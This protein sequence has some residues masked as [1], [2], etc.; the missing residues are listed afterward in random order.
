MSGSSAEVICELQFM[1]TQGV[2]DSDLSRTNSSSA[3]FDASGTAAPGINNAAEVIA[4]VQA[5]IAPVWPLR[6]FVAVNPFLGLSDRSFLNARRL[7]RSVADCE[8]L[9][10]V[11]YYQ[12][13]YQR[14]DFTGD[15]LKSAMDELSDSTGF[16]HLKLAAVLQTLSETPVSRSAAENPERVIRSMA[17][18]A[19][20][21]T[22]CEWAEIVREEVGRHCAAMYDE[23]QAVWNSPWKALTL[24]Q[25]WKAAAQRDRRADAL[26][27]RTLRPLAA[28]IPENP[29]E[30]MAYLLQRLEV[31]EDLQQAFLLCLAHSI[32][33]WSAWTKYKSNQAEEKQQLADDFIGL[34]AIRL[35]YDVA[36]AEQCRL[37]ASWRTLSRVRKT[38]SRSSQAS[39]D[40]DSALRY[41]LLRATEV[42]YERSLL[43][44]LDTAGNLNSSDISGGQKTATD[45]S[46]AQMV[47]CIDVR[48][49]RHR[50]SVES[51]SEDVQTYGFAGFFGVPIALQALGE[52]DARPQLPAL[53]SP[54]ITISES[55]RG[56]SE[57]EMAGVSRRR[58]VQRTLRKTWKQFQT[59]AIGC[60][61]FVETAGV[62]FGWKLFAKSLG[63]VP[64]D[65][66]F[67][68]V[69]AKLRSRLGPDVSN[70]E[71]AG[72]PPDRQIAMA[73][74]I[75]RGIGI[76]DHFAKLVVLCG[77]GST[78]QNNPLQAG[79]DCG[80]CCGHTGEANARLAAALLNNS[81]VRSGLSQRGIHIPGGTVFLAALH[82]T[83][84]DDV[85]YFDTDLLT[86]ERLQSLE[87]LTQHT[88][89]A[90]RRCQLE[91]LPQIQAESV[92]HLL[93]RTNDWS[94]VRPEWGLAG[95]AAFIVGP[96]SVTRTANLE[97]R[98]FLHSYNFRNDTEFKVLEQIMTAPMVVA[99]W[100]N[101]QYYASTVDNKH[102]GSGDKTI[103]NVVGKF[104]IYSGNGG[105]LTTGLPWQSVHNGREYQHEPLRLLCVIV[106]PCQAVSEILQRHK[107][108]ENLLANGWLN[109]VVLDE[110]HWFRFTTARN[111]V[112]IMKP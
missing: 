76:I 59:S 6:D 65:R 72:L 14:G 12:K 109:L 63:R 47:F 15:D 81:E 92:K 29:T 55:V 42:A 62:T 46:L 111:R 20:L 58:R 9:M 7:L 21:Q 49:E 67:D 43:A 64:T 4:S 16:S 104:G 26:G 73:E 48:S 45:Q 34:I 10:P 93:K 8:T 110:G 41:V 60:F 32:P 84:R 100:I 91:R 85:Q 37:H 82:D 2:A 56:A 71:D 3:E 69:R 18:L 36:I 17:E 98:S 35:A 79:L 103:H 86:P 80:A 107:T 31:P 106:A 11:S 51:A 78:T 40:G 24:F 28:D 61:A 38:A 66:R 68:G 99:N 102:F 53:L 50:R 108:V 30:C 105:D 77:H 23:G 25:A 74:S 52:T 1:E 96:R 57:S 27:L 87:E 112:P 83:T 22:G 89:D 75:L 95:N 44:S 39:T 5:M 19:D 97:A 88:F 90:T 54:S 101:M 70:L 33:G 94:E 13:K